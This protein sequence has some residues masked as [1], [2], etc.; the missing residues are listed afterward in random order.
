MGDVRSF[1]ESKYLGAWDL[2]EDDTDYVV[3]IARVKP[4]TIV[5][6]KG[7]QD[8]K[9]L[10][11][12]S[13][14]KDPEKPMVVNKTNGKII[15]RVLGTWIDTEWAGRSIVLYRGEVERDGELMPALKI[16]PYG[17]DRAKKKARAGDVVDTG[18]PQRDEP[19]GD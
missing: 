10:L 4:G 8:K 16:R 13:N 15:A 11:Y 9:P 2:P 7:R 18:T 3:T 14:T 17:A 6:E 12:F 19:K 1:Y 5:G